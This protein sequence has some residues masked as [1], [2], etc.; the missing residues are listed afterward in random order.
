[1]RVARKRAEHFIADSNKIA[2]RDQ[3]AAANQVELELGWR[4]ECAIQLSL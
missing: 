1:V 2:R 4:T 3:A